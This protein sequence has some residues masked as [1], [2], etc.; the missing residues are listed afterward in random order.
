MFSIFSAQAIECWQCT[1]H[2]P[3][4]DDPFNPHN[5]TE[6]QKGSFY[7]ECVLSDGQSKINQIAVCQKLKRIG[8]IFILVSKRACDSFFTI[9]N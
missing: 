4:C 3:F 9:D 2:V 6:H 7:K 8:K 5:A 1:S